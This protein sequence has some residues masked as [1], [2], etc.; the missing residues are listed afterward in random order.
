M[1]NEYVLTDRTTATKYAVVIDDGQLLYSSTAN[2]ASSEP[3]FQDDT[4]AS[5]YWKLFIDNSL[6]A[7]ES[8]VTI[9]DDDVLL[10]DQTSGEV[11]KLVVND[12]SFGW[13][14]AT[15]GS[16]FYHNKITISDYITQII[17]VVDSGVYH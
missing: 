13:T 6:I 4:N 2:A 17:E 14:T 3:I 1:A 11:F 7:I 5:D 12:G 15:T 16:F 9:Q 10:T 8:T